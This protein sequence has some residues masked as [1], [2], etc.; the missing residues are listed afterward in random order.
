MHLHDGVIDPSTVAVGFAAAAGLFA[1]S[2][3]RVRDEEIP[4]IAVLTAA[5]F[6]ASLIHIPAGPSS[7]HLTLNGLTGILLRRR[8]F[9]AFPVGLFLQVTLGH[10]GLSV[11]GVNA[12]IFGFPAFASWL[13]YDILSRRGEKNYFLSGAVSGALAVFLSGLMLGAVLWLSSEE[14][15]GFAEF[16]FIAHIPLMIMEGIITGFVI[17][18]LSRVQPSLVRKGAS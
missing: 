7:V 1:W 9:L 13:I 8:A 3:Y 2:A 12:C 6:V 14:F 17:Q 16:V 10:G 4:R 18:F 15:K 5:F 11:I